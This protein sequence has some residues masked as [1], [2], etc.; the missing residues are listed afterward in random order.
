MKVLLSIDYICHQQ[1][2]QN[3]VCDNNCPLFNFVCFTAQHKYS[4][5]EDTS[6]VIKEYLK[7]EEKDKIDT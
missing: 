1:Y 2:K 4:D 3:G 7:N 6:D 5:L